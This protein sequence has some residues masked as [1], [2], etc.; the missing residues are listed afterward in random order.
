MRD[1]LQDSTR[2]MTLADQ[3]DTLRL[4]I[5]KPG[6]LDTLRFIPDTRMLLPL[7][8]HE[9]EIQVKATGLKLVSPNTFLIQQIHTKLTYT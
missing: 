4:T 8:D 9:V 6:L 3:D 7:Q 1:H 2:L 5:G